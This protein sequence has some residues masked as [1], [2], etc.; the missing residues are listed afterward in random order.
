MV[1]GE[2]YN[3]FP[4]TNYNNVIKSKAINRTSSGI[5]R[6]LDIKDVTG[7]YSST[8]IYS[9]DGAIY[10]NEFLKNKTFSWLND[11]DIY[12]SIRNIV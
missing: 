1:N 8:N 5:S 12:D 3:I 6:F 10:K 7:K 11:N 2:D 9:N 4:L